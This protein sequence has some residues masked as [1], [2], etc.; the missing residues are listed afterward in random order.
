MR[1][2]GFD[3]V[4]TECVTEQGKEWLIMGCPR[5]GDCKV[6]MF[7]DMKEELLVYLNEGLLINYTMI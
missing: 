4:V 7:A 5:A 2:S 1:K 6:R 3:E